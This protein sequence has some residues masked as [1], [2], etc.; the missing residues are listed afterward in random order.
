MKK[1]SPIFLAAFI[2][3]FSVVHGNTKV[4]APVATYD[5]GS[6]TSETLR[7]YIETL[8]DVF[9]PISRFV[10][11]RYKP[12]EKEALED[13]VFQR[14]VAEKMR[15]EG[16]DKS[17]DFIRKLGNV[18]EYLASQK[19]GELFQK[20]ATDSITE[21]QLL[22]YYEKHKNEYPIGDTGVIRYI[23]KECGEDFTPE[24]ATKIADEMNG[25]LRQIK[26]SGLKDEALKTLFTDLLRKHSESGTAKRENPSKTLERGKCSKELFDT[27]WRLNKGEVSGVFRTKNGFFLVLLEDKRPCAP[28]PFRDVKLRIQGK[29]RSDYVK[30]KWDDLRE[31]VV[32]IDYKSL[33]PEDLKNLGGKPD[34]YILFLVGSCKYKLGDFEKD[35]RD[36][37]HKEFEKLSAEEVKKAFQQKLLNALM[38]VYLERE[39]FLKKYGID[40]KGRLYA[41]AILAKM[42]LD[43]RLSEPV[44]PTERE[45][46]EYYDRRKVDFLSQPAREARI[47]K[48]LTGMKADASPREIHYALKSAKEKLRAVEDGIKKGVSFEELAR[49][50]SDDVSAK[51]GGYVGWVKEPSS[52]KFDMNAE[53]LKPGETSPLITL[54]GERGWMFI[55]LLNVRP[56]TP[57]PYNEVKKKIEARIKFERRK[58]AQD[59][60]RGNILKKAHLQIFLSRSG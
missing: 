27:V 2:F 9:S 39:G 14:I 38:V 50:Y 11:M 58:G 44:E 20:E 59:K 49:K 8:G 6:V 43:E 56:R 60:I 51:D 26:D 1:I 54:S 33:K 40:E 31:K 37:L 15:K 32:R 42:Y 12:G 36:I 22:S 25:I 13:M 5:G 34:D 41:D 46:R 28:K 29:M 53:K 21:P 4:S 47:I 57:L 17:A 23:F 24:Q 18:K 30:F 7:V 48:I 52:A 10:P 16:T 35:L 19:L 55:K 45:M 3:V